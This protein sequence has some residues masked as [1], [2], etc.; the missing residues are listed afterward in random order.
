M[1]RR[2]KLRSEVTG[3]IQVALAMCIVGSSVAIGKV[4]SAEMPV[5][6]ASFVRFA[7][8]S[9]FVVPLNYKMIG[10]LRLPSSKVMMLL[11]AQAFFGVFLFS[12]FLLLGLKRTAALNAGVILGML[13]AVNALLSVLILREKLNFHYLIGICLSVLGAILLELRSVDSDGFNI[14]M[15]GTLL[16][17]GAVFCE[18][19]FSVVGK[20]S[21]LSLP[22]ISVTCWVTLIGMVLF[23]P[24]A[25][26]EAISFDFRNVS[27]IVWFLLVY[28]G[29]VVTVIGFSLFYAG[30]SRISAVSAGVHMAFVPLSAMA[31]AVLLLGES[32]GLTDVF[33]S[34]LV[35]AAVFV[36][37]L[38][39]EKP[40]QSAQVTSGSMPRQ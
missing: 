40:V 21:G 27:P 22:A 26:Y 28:Y 13:P 35:L 31:I 20:L 11:G 24:C 3:H 15:A 10:S 25:L 19:M 5:F 14:S 6:L 38:N 17:L 39:S 29:V 12:V 1:W 30:L 16:I 2:E 7:I 34:L 9:L 8:A 36:I 23:M 32:F 33:S 37:G 4:I 18:G